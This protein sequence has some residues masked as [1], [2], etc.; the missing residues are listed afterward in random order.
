MDYLV[1]T[2]GFRLKKAGRTYTCT[3]CKDEITRGEK[4]TVYETGDR[5]HIWCEPVEPEDAEDQIVRG[6]LQSQ[7]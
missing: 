4:T 1:D 6:Y 5:N 2:E 3:I 7:R